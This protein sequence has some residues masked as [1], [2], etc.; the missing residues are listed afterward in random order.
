M[1][2]VARDKASIWHPYTTVSE[3]EFSIFIEK[4]TGSYLFTEDGKAILDAVGS[5]WVNLHGHSHPYIAEKIAAQAQNLEHVMF[6]GFTHKPAIELAEAL[7]GL[8]KGQFSKVFYSDN[9]STSIEV[10]LKMCFQFWYNKGSAKRKVLALEGAYHGDTFGAMS[11]GERSVFT[12]AFQPFLFD[13]EYLPLSEEAIPKAK[14]LLATGDFAC[15]IFEPLIQGAAGMV[16]YEA[17]WLD[18]L[19]GIAK[20]NEVLCIADEVFTGFG[21]TGKA[22]AIDH[23]T[24]LVDII[25]LSKGLTG[26]ALPLGVTLCTQAIH[27]A[28]QENKKAP[29]DLEG[30]NVKTFF[31]GHS[32]T[33]N[34]IACAAALASL[35]L[36]EQPSCQASILA[37]EKQHLDFCE[38]FSA[39]NFP[40][41]VGLRSKGVVL[42]VTYKAERR[43]GY[44]SEMRNRLYAYFLEK[45]ILMRPLG[46]TVYVVPP[47]CITSEELDIIYQAILSFE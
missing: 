21:R 27:D 36:F 29:N 13:V 25:C 7:L 23:L 47:Y 42:A 31:H 16:M 30:L 4:A 37:I 3:T 9:G 18:R 43:Q 19:I 22:F 44:L 8:F 45:G 32:F 24:V 26:G 17:E 10:A 11:V 40:S 12:Q 33:A 1:G 14:E 28:F 34:P 20:Q 46:N 2:F 38:R 15:F 35:E 39:K 6:A 41:I 5:W